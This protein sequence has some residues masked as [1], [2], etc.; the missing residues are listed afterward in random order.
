MSSFNP[1]LYDKT[2]MVNV[3]DNRSLNIRE[4]G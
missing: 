1:T 3:L 2:P 4:I